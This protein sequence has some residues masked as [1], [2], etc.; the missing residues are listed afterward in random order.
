MRW[1][2]KTLWQWVTFGSGLVA[3]LACRAQPL[4]PPASEAAGTLPGW[5]DTFTARLEAL[6]LLQTLNAD[7]LSHDSATLTLERWCAAHR[8]ASPPQIVADQ[9]PQIHKPPT[10]RQRQELK[11]TPTELVRYRQV[12]LRCGSHVLSVAENWYVPARLTADM[13][14]ALQT[15]DIPFGRVV[16]P[17][18]FSRHTLQAT[19]VWSPLP[20]G[21]ESGHQAAPSAWPTPQATLISHRAILTLPDGRPISE[22]VEHYTAEVLAFPQPQTR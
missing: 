7:L 9:L 6:A 13:N 20:V 19:L 1:W 11:V 21:W 17:L 2:T 14:R 15:T 8:M 22:V 3:A 10:A 4:A 12:R 16:Q 5:H 18:H